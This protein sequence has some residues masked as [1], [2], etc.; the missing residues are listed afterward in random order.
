M[1]HCCTYGRWY[2]FSL[3]WIY[4]FC[5][6]CSVT[7]LSEAELQTMVAAVQHGASLTGRHPCLA[8]HHLTDDM[9]EEIEVQCCALVRVVCTCTTVIPSISLYRLEA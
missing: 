4:V 7:G 6:T 1:A 9:V 5:C 3:R 8:L 2:S